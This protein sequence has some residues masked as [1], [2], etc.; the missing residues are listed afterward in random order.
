M[1]K[2]ISCALAASFVFA[3][4]GCGTLFRSERIGKASSDR[5]DPAIMILDCCG[6]LFGVIP[7]VVA[8]VL[9]FNN[10][11]I[12]FSAR[13]AGIMPGTTDNMVAI[14][15]EDMSEESIAAALSEALGREIRYDE[16]QFAAR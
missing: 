2:T 5:I 15:V 10:K 16:I 8:L 1:K 14:Q 12:Y 11:T 13:E 3:A 6:L 9:D 4:T 7:G